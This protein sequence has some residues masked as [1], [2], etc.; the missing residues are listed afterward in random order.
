M[1]V[2]FAAALMVIVAPVIALAQQSPKPPALT[3][4]LAPALA[5]LDFLLGEWSGGGKT[6][7]GGTARGT[8]TIHAVAGGGGLLRQD[9]TEVIGKDGKPV[10]GASFDQIMLIY[11]EGG[12]LHADYLDGQHTIHYTDAQV[13]P[14][15]SVTFLAAATPSSP[16]FRLG[17]AKVGPGALHVKFEMAPPGAPGF[18]TVAEGDV[19]R[20]K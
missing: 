18:M 16:G 1:R 19:T 8:S 5:P 13:V 11:P 4:A 14:G 15:E 20:R 9:H 3:P 2:L 17:Y 12:G 7:D 6:E 10:P